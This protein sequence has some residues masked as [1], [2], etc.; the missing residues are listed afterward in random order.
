MVQE[1]T[2]RPFCTNKFTLIE[3]LISFFYIVYVF[4]ANNFNYLTIIDNTT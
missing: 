3:A 2:L 1:G 4:K